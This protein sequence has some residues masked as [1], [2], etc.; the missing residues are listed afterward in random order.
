MR[1]VFDYVPLQVKLNIKKK[2]LLYCQGDPID[3]MLALYINKWH[4]TENK[5]K[6]LFIRE[7]EGV[8]QFGTKKIF[9]AI[10]QDKIHSLN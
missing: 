5:L 6:I 1:T 9:V 7:G 4:S 10:H 8:Y 2:F 3:S